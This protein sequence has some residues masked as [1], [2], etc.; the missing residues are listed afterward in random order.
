MEKK[1]RALVMLTKR[2]P[3][4]SRL[5]FVACREE[6]LKHGI[7]MTFMPIPSNPV[8][9]LKLFLQMKQ[10]DVVIIQ[11]K[12][13]FKRYELTFIRYLNPNIIFDY[14]D[15]VMFHELEH[16]KTLMGKNVIKF[17]RTIK[18]CRAVVAGNNF[19]AEFARPNCPNVFVLPTPID[20]ERY[21]LKDYSEK[22]DK[23][24]IGWIG[25]SGNLKYLKRLEPVLK[26]IS[27]R[28][29]HTVL[30]IISN[31]SIKLNGVKIEFKK[32]RLEDEIEDLRSIDIGIM[33][34]DNSLWA[35]GKCGYK[36]L[37]YMGVG[38]PVVASPVG[39][40]VEFIKHGENGFLATS[41]EDWLLSLKS[42]I[43]NPDMRKTF[44]MKGRQILE[45]RY[46]LRRYAEKYSSIIK[47]YDKISIG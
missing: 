32:W 36:I 12:T 19:L 29:P 6:F 10:H 21:R 38:V 11:K 18:Y 22:K 25:V 33:P 7:E 27:E 46:S 28:Y 43:R 41:D 31:D 47:R 40:N 45:E 2:Q 17:L 8:G 1:I 14:D 35:R 23:V 15:A 24:T 16:G 34:I 26:N 20:M 30:K 13:S 9:R 42:L 3:P 4:S 37:Q 5:R 39:I 44:G